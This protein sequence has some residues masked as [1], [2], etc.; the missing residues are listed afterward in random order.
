MKKSLLFIII[1]LIISFS[2]CNY[3]ESDNP[4]GISQIELNISNLKPLA[5]TLVYAGWITTNSDSSF[6]IFESNVN[7]SGVI[8]V[9]T[10]N[11]FGGL[12]KAQQF[13]VTV[14]KAGIPDSLATPG[15][16]V[17]LSGRFTLGAAQLKT[18]D[19]V[20][21]S[22]SSGAYTITTPTDTL[23]NNLSGVWFTGLSDGSVAGLN[24]P[25]LHEGWTYE[26]WVVLNNDTLSTGKFT[27]PE[28]ADD[29]SGYSGS[30][31]GFPFPGEDFLVNP[32]AGLTFPVDLSNAK[33]M[34]TLEFISNNL[35]PPFLFTIFEGT[36]P[37]GVQGNST[38]AFQ[39]LDAQVP[40]GVVSIEVD[41]VE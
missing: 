32:P 17:I 19:G 1:T 10:T 15:S 30:A 20:N 33:V 11:E 25:V 22:S 36:V 26:G 34:V 13:K 2:A 31:P 16:T 12:Q 5:D 41:L 24:L 9:S 28:A 18:G 35:T 14:E 3:F 37:A 23:D 39:R 38:H 7:Q 8:T 21:F 29:F 27:D 40:S 4:S 6:R